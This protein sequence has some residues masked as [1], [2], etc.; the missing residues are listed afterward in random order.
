VHEAVVRDIDA[1]ELDAALSAR[2][3]PPIVGGIKVVRVAL[4][5]GP[6]ALRGLVRSAPTPADH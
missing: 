3:E 2:Y 1:L 6:A 4:K 5:E